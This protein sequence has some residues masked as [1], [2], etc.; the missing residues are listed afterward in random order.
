MKLSFVLSLAIVLNSLTGFSHMEAQSLRGEY[1]LTGVPEM[2]SGFKFL[3]DGHFTFFY[4]YGAVDRTAQG[5]YT[6]IGHT[7]ALKIDKEPGSDF[8]IVSQKKQGTGYAI[9]INDPNAYLASSVRCL[10]FVDGQQSET[11]ADETGIIRIES[12]ECGKI[13]VQHEFYPDIASLIKD[14]DNKNNVFELTLK[15]QLQQVSFKGIELT[16]DGD[17]LSCLPNYILPMQNPRF[18]K[19]R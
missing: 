19:Q 7:I 15:P 18:V 12:P 9:K 3:P 5:T 17:T 11:F 8:N 2:A 10:Y 6:S 14:D 16:I 1:Y 4:S 13:Y